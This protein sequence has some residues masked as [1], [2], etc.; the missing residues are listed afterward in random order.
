MAD[1]D[2]TEPTLAELAYVPAANVSFSSSP[3]SSSL[4]ASHFSTELDTD[5]CL[6]E[7][8]TDWYPI[9]VSTSAEKKK[10]TMSAINQWSSSANGTFIL[11]AVTYIYYGTGL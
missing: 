4:D 9:S 10:K 1:Q 11:Q 6:T 8:E 5:W 2:Y 3:V 7:V